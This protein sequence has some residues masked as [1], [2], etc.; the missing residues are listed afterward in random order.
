M[1]IRQLSSRK[2]GSSD[3]WKSKDGHGRPKHHGIHSR[4]TGEFPIGNDKDHLDT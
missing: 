4:L 1:G 2:E 3:S